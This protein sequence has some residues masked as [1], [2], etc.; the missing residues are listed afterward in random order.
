M[1]LSTFAMNIEEIIKTQVLE[2]V[3]KKVFIQ[4]TL[5]EIQEQ[6]ENYL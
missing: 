3:W 6:V 1:T 2:K 5:K 4:D